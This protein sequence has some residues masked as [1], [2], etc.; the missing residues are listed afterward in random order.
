M[1]FTEG[2]AT[3]KAGIQKFI[4][5]NTHKE[6]I[7]LDEIDKMPIKDQEGLLA[8]MKGES[9]QVPKSGI[10]NSKSQHRNICNIK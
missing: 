7:I 9:L 5:E 3:T 1:Y 8:M 6:I 2:G 10:H 4:A